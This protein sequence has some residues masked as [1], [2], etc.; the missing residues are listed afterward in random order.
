[1]EGF[2]PGRRFSP[3]YH[4]IGENAAFPRFRGFPLRIPRVSPGYSP[5]F[6]HFSHKACGTNKKTAAEFSPVFSLFLPAVPPPGGERRFVSTFPDF[7]PPQIHSG[8]RQKSGRKSGFPPFFPISTAP[9]ID[10]DKE[11]VFCVVD[12]R[13]W[14]QLTSITNE[15]C[16]NSPL[17]M[18]VPGTICQWKGLYDHE[19]HL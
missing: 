13:E 5:V 14:A 10:Y 18:G 8:R 4:L 12:S 17:G 9:T 3:I 15:G 2:S 19:N 11:R 16:G 7:S 6:L 1:M